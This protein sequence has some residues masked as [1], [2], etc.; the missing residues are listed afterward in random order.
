MEQRIGT[1]ALVALQEGLADEGGDVEDTTIDVVNDVFVAA[2]TSLPEEWPVFARWNLATGD[3]AGD[4]TSY[5]WAE[6]L[7]GID[8]TAHGHDIHDDNRFYPLAAS[9]Y[10]LDFAGGEL[11][12]ANLDDATGLDFSLHAVTVDSYDGPVGD[13]VLTWEGGAT[14]DTVV[15]TVDPGSY[16]LVGTYPELAD[17][18]VKIEFCLG[19]A[20]A[21]DDCVDSEG[22]DSGPGGDDPGGCAC[23]SSGA[24]AP[25][26][27]LLLPLLALGRRRPDGSAR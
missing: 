22:E 24:P 9:Y 6:A 7:E 17:Q 27:S 4:A 26:F 14:A 19:D 13:A 3:R 5:P 16:W 15:G 25:W 11:H 23:A 18:S 2:G 10:R 8:D 21:V 12:F 1:D 20:G